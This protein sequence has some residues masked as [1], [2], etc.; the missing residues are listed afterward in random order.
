MRKQPRRPQTPAERARQRR[1]ENLD[2]L[3]GALGFFT[4]VVFL[5]TA[6]GEIRGESSVLR[7]LL[8]AVLVVLFWVL[9]RVRRK[10]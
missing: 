1:R 5:L 8:L 3:L 9:L 6:I 7:P 10:V 2:M 4:A